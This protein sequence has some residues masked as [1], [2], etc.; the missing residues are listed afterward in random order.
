MWSAVRVAVALLTTIGLTL[1]GC[2]MIE[3]DS[4]DAPECGPPRK[5]VQTI[6]EANALPLCEGDDDGATRMPSPADSDQIMN[7]LHGY[8]LKV[9]T[10][11]DHSGWASA[12]VCASLLGE[13]TPKQIGPHAAKWFS[14]GEKADAMLTEPQ[15]RSIVDLIVSQRWCSIS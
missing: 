5:G 11:V 2:S 8:G 12:S 7:K 4:E 10:V 13:A 6:D 9:D 1:G 3:I 14:Q 15:A